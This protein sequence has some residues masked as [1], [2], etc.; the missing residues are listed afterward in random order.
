VIGK[1]DLDTIALRDDFAVTLSRLDRHEE[2]LGNLLPA[3]RMRR[4]APASNDGA[5]CDTMEALAKACERMDRFE[6]ALVLQEVRFHLALQLHC[7]AA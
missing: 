4:A 2:A 7:T 6:D 1:K 5:T 3:L